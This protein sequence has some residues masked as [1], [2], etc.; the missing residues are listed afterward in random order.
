MEELQKAINNIE[1]L[2][3]KTSTPV[4]KKT[5]LA[6][7]TKL[8]EW[9]IEAIDYLKKPA[10]NENNKSDSNSLVAIGDNNTQNIITK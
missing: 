9:H 1:E 6:L 2:I 10:F 8:N 7:I 4:M 3:P 5:R